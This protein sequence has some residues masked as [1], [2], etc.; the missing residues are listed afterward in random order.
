MTDLTKEIILN[1]PAGPRINS[2]ISERVMGLSARTST[3]KRGKSTLWY[4]DSGELVNR[5]WSTDIAAAM[6]V[7]DTLGVDDAGQFLCKSDDGWSLM[8]PKRGERE[9]IFSAASTAPLAICQ[10]ALLTTLQASH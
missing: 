9:P 2:W 10:A 1:E 7:W 8:L 6:G 5:D 3:G 4:T